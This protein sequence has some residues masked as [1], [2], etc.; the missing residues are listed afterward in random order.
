MLDID[1]FKRVNDTYG[2][3]IGDIVLQEFVTTIKSTLRA[4]EVFARLGGEEFVILIPHSSQ[5][6][7]LN[8]AQS[9]VDIVAIHTIYSDDIKLNVTVSIGISEYRESDINASEALKRADKAL[10]S[11]KESGRNRVSLQD[12]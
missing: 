5:E 6:Q 8:F 12:K 10:Y 2:H 1:F 11:A 7:A 4:D 9:L 3:D